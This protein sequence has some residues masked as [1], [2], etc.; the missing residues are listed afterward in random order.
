MALRAGKRGENHMN[1]FV[2]SN[3]GQN[4]DGVHVEQLKD[5]T[6]RAWTRITHIF[7]SQVDAAPIEGFGGTEADARAALTKELRDFNDSLWA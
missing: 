3:I 4:D 2:C 7:G 5:G 1:A 6:F